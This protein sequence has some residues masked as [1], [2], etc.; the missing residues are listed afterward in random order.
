[1]SD[2]LPGHELESP[3]GVEAVLAGRY[4]V[5]ESPS[6]QQRVEQPADPGP[7]SRRPEHG[8]RVIPIEIV[9]EGQAWHIGLQ[10]SMAVKHA[11]RHAGGARRIHQQRRIVGPSFDRREVANIRFGHRGEGNLIALRRA[12]DNPVTQRRKHLLGVAKTGPGPVLGND[13]DGFSMIK[14]MGQH[15]RPVELRQCHGDGAELV[16]GKMRQS[17][18]RPQPRMNGDPVALADA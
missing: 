15:I 9:S 16:D 4:G 14:N 12:D 11:L 1:M 17:R 10:D 18:F 3:F 2:L 13:R 8:V 7:V 5:A 6:D